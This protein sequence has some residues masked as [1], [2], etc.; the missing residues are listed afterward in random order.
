MTGTLNCAGGFVTAPLTIATNGTLNISGVG[1]AVESTLTNA[2]TVNWLGG[3]VFL[4]C[5]EGNPGPLVNLAGAL[6][7]VQSD[8]TMSSGCVAGSAYFQNA[9]TFLKTN[10]TGT[11][12]I[13]IPFY[14]SGDAEGRA[15]NDW[16]V[17]RRDTGRNVCGL[18]GC[19]D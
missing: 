18:L 15:G 2:G 19:G 3:A 16:S 11:T 12:T 1:V 9:G 6:W 4:N 5:N 10:A 13:S 14:N 17:G 7:S 8:Q